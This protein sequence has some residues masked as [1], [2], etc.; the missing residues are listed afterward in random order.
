MA[1]KLVYT[2]SPKGLQPGAYGFCVVAATRGLHDRVASFLAST[3]GY[4][5]V[6]SPESGQANLNPVS[7][8]HMIVDNLG[9]TF[10]ILSR[11][12]DAG[13]DYTNRTNKIA[14]FLLP[15]RNELVSAGPAALFDVP[16]LFYATWNQEP[17]W[18][19]PTPIPAAPEPASTLC[20]EW[21]RVMGAPD[22]GAA[23][24][25]T[26]Y[27]GAP[28]ALV[29]EPGRNVDV[30]KMFQESIHLLPVN[31]RWN[32]TFS[33]YFTQA[34]LGAQCQWKAVLAGSPEEA[35]MRA[36][37]RVV[38]FDLTR[39][40]GAM[41]EVGLAS[42]NGAQL[43]TLARGA[44]PVA[45]PTAVPVPGGVPFGANVPPVAN[46][47]P[48]NAFPPAPQPQGGAAFPPP[49][50]NGA[51]FD[52]SGSPGIYGI[53]QFPGG[54]KPLNYGRDWV[55]PEDD[56]LVGQ[57]RQQGRRFKRTIFLVI[58]IICGLIA[59]GVL[60]AL[61]VCIT[62]K[63]KEIKKEG[64]KEAEPSQ[65]ETTPSPPA[66][67]ELSKLIST[68]TDRKDAND[69]EFSKTE[70]EEV[71][72]G[73]METGKSIP[74]GIGS[75]DIEPVE[76]SKKQSRQSKND[77]N[78][79]SKSVEA[80]NDGSTADA[81]LRGADGESTEN[82]PTEQTVAN[83]PAEIA[84][85]GESTEKA[86][87]EAVATDVTTEEVLRTSDK[88][89]W[90][91]YAKSFIDSVDQGDLLSNEDF[92]GD[93]VL[94]DLIG[95]YE[96]GQKYKD[97]SGICICKESV[98]F[99]DDKRDSVISTLPLLLKILQKNVG[100]NFRIAIDII[101]KDGSKVII[102][103]EPDEWKNSSDGKTI[104]W[105]LSR[106]SKVKNG[107]YESE[108]L[109]I[110]SDNYPGKQMQAT[111]LIG[112]KGWIALVFE[113]DESESLRKDFSDSFTMKI[114]FNHGSD[115]LTTEE[116]QIPQWKSEEDDSILVDKKSKVNPFYLKYLFDNNNKLHDNNNHVVIKSCKC[117]DPSIVI[118]AENNINGQNNEEIKIKGSGWET[119]ILKYTL[120]RNNLGT[121]DELDSTSYQ[122]L[123]PK[124]IMV[125]VKLGCR[126]DSD[127]DSDTRAKKL[128]FSLNEL[129]RTPL[130]NE[131]IS[132]ELLDESF[133]IL[134][135]EFKKGEDDPVSIGK[136]KIPCKAYKPDN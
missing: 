16:G 65:T 17:T 131:L 79:E 107:V 22:W 30:L 21:A 76:D 10:R 32:A 121:D 6:F 133:I 47:M 68:G 118:R 58:K 25:A 90:Q 122:S 70:A 101:K 56:A 59:A 86:P 4:R 134:E 52:C 123:N 84:T 124:D 127:K 103:S 112:E 33:T 34:P 113:G 46:A 8:T 89:E 111:F 24:A 136:L 37:P 91:N 31:M 44:A 35:T 42:P 14:S 51:P 11:V 19:E 73:E 45:T 66:D 94:A 27:S 9:Q 129:S 135:L 130:E 116:I 92:D 36:N 48:G 83:K 106:N 82:N 75:A 60:A 77:E 110:S 85:A 18:F 26:V 100:G 93:H 74:S 119:T 99:E 5:R 23:L 88:D 49:V 61:I 71:E 38:I 105:Y 13:L 81:K 3:S 57:K 95:D 29:Y 72:T 54:T 7:Y 128:G 63:L 67:P 43:L 55:Q 120:S 1:Q 20:S 50:A 102:T 41:P 108:A 96:N 87:L 15:D 126:Q 12:A 97:K 117:T 104:T 64:E 115:D 114:R 2:S 109:L 80:T 69:A 98:D 39:P 132:Q 125:E 78:Q 40:G 53:Q 62:N 28:V